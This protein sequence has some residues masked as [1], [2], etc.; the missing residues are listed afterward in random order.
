MKRVKIIM[1]ALLLGT[2]ALPAYAQQLKIGLVDFQ[3]ALNE[4]EEGKRAKA[5]LKAQFESKQ[6]ALNAK[7]E[8]LKKLKNELEERRESSLPTV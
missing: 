3:K 5:G 6:K 7:Q 4:V 2:L 1:I 8:S